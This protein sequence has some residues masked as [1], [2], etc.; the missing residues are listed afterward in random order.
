MAASKVLASLSVRCLLQR[1]HTHAPPGEHTPHTA[2]TQVPAPFHRTL[3]IS[4]SFTSPR[5]QRAGTTQRQKKE[6]LRVQASGLGFSGGD[7][8]P[9]CT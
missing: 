6:A 2:I 1:Q 4:Q 8:G 7:R 9:G 3:A 5:A